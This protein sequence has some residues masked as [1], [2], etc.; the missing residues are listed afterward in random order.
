ALVLMLKNSEENDY[1][2]VS[3]IDLGAFRFDR[4]SKVVMF[5]H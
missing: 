1:G 3:Y 4:L 5:D 2:S